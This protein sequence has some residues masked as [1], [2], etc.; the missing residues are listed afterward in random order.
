M[1][2]SG[3]FSAAAVVAFG[4]LSQ[5]Q[6]TSLD[7]LDPGNTNIG[8]YMDQLSGF[9]EQ[10]ISLNSG[11]GT[12]LSGTIGSGLPTVSF[13]TD[14]SATAASGFA[15]IAGAFNQ[16]TIS[17]NAAAGFTG[18]FGDLLF[19][20]QLEK[21]KPLNLKIDAF[22]GA[23]DLGSF[24]FSDSVLKHDADM[25]FGVLGENS[26]IT[27]IVL[28]STSGFKEVKHFQ[29]SDLQE[30][31]TGEC[32]G[33]GPHLGTPLPAAVWLFGSVLAG[34]AGIGRWRKRRKAAVAA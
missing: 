18:A 30:V 27:S 21:N 33:G 8:I 31:C 12:N 14:A 28:T 4:Y 1:M 15:N 23:T 5:A 6:A 9:G 10:K 16:L 17:L 25:S 20:L 19:D 24:T 11:T 26:F 13:V 29:I 3:L 22:N 32:G 2:R 7:L 34:G